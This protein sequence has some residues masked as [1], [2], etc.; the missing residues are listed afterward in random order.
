[1][2]DLIK[3]LKYDGI[4]NLQTSFLNK[5]HDISNGPTNAGPS[6]LFLPYFNGMLCVDKRT[7]SPRLNLCIFDFVY[8]VGHTFVQ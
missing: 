8:L 7:R 5:T 3:S 6:F 1:M 2:N 4:C